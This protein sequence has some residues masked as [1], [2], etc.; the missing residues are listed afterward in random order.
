MKDLFASDLVLSAQ[1]PGAEVHLLEAS[2]HRDGCRMD[3]WIKPAVG[4]LL[5]MAYIFAEHRAL[6]AYIT[7]QSRY[8]FDTQSLIVANH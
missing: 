3:I 5:G 2:I 7:L 1:T 4:M 6:A 8:S